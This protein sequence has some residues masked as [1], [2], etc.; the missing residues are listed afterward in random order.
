MSDT[1]RTQI[2][3]PRDLLELFWQRSRARG[4]TPAQNMVAALRTYL[5]NEIDPVLRGGILGRK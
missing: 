5:D 1:V 4:G 2:E 3:I